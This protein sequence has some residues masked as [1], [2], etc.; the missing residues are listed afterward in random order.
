MNNP[1]APYNTGPTGAPQTEGLAVTSLV[2][3]ILAW[4][5]CSIFAGIPAIIC[6]HIGRSRISTSNGTLAG[7]G[8]AIAGLV[9]G[10]LSVFLPL[11]LIIGV[12]VFGLGAAML[13][14]GFNLPALQQKIA[15][16]TLTA[17][18]PKIAAACNQYRADK[19]KFPAAT[20]LSGEQ[21]DSGELFAILTTADANGKVYYDASGSGI[22]VNGTPRDP[23]NE[24]IQVALDLNGD[25][26]VNVNGT[27]VNAS[28]VVWSKGPNKTNEFGSGDDVKLW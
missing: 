1:Y 19:G 16:P 28:V 13:S 7:G 3:G 17:M 27:L 5:A 26:R 2:L 6:G 11:I 4:V 9:L 10:Y 25:G 8:I 15:V 12:L 18:S 24:M 21:V 20:V 23:W 22:H 14:T